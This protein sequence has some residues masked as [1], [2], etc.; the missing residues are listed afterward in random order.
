[1][2]AIFTC[3]FCCCITVITFGQRSL[4]RTADRYCQEFKFSAAAEAYERLIKNDPSDAYVTE[5]LAFCYGKLNQPQK[6]VIWLARMCQAENVDAVYL[7][8]YAGTLA[9][10]GKYEEASEWYR[11]YN[12]RVPGDHEV[13]AILEEYKSM[14]RFSR[15]SSFY[16]V[17]YLSLNS[18]QS[19]FSPA[20]YREGIVFCSA[21][22]TAAKN[23]V[24]SWNNSTFIDLYV[25]R[26]P[27]GE[28]TKFDKPVNTAWHEGPV[29]FSPSFDTLFFTRNNKARTK[30]SD[31]IV[32]LMLYYTVWKDGRWLKEIALPFNSDKY[33]VGHPALSPDGK[34]F[35]IS[36]KP[37][38]FGGTD[39][40]YTKLVNGKW[41]EP[42]NAG[43]F[44][45]TRGNEMFPFAGNDGHLYFASNAHPGL[46]G[47]DV[48][49]SK[50]VEGSFTTPHNLGRPINSPDD[51][52]GFIINNDRGY[53]SSNRGGNPNDDNIYSF[54]I[55]KTKFLHFIARDPN[56]KRISEFTL[57]VSGDQ[58]VPVPVD[59]P[60]A[61]S[62]HCEKNYTLAYGKEGYQPGS[63]TLT[64][65]QLLLHAHHDT[66]Y[67]TLREALKTIRFSLQATNG[68]KLNKGFIEI[69]NQVTGAVL[70]YPV[71]NQGLCT[72][73]LTEHQTYEVTGMQSPYRNKTLTLT[74]ADIARADVIH[75]VLTP[76]A[77][78]FEKNEIGQLI[79]LEIKYDVNKATIRADAAKELDKL[80][81]FLKKNPTIKVELGSHTDSRG[82]DEANLKLSQKRAEAAVRYLMAQGISNTRLIPIGY[83]EDDLKVKNAVTEEEHQKNRRTTV[84]IVGI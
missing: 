32:R 75:V 70:Q 57:S 10:L 6:S 3:L 8:H 60:Y 55:D 16:Q 46:G 2:K 42:V 66:I 50:I 43:P 28:L 39:I 36:D 35:F 83:G 73:T 17:E 19:D 82:S 38:G 26:N 13:A 65:D 58:S 47:L 40:Y 27:D 41:M 4:L 9:A 78:L 52:F 31:G 51:D 59:A 71:D 30:G 22:G 64:S 5:R 25:A 11:K 67:F 62:F 74:S 45:N 37:G 24:Y 61:F 54:T 12:N 44:V 56:G 20:F 53:F 63:V 49:A 84:K 77:A 21:R 48:F 7:K 33:S 15:F 72:A 81:V 69:K 80:I 34:L 68:S 14:D 76:A 79:E 18:P 23:S 29:S 1:M